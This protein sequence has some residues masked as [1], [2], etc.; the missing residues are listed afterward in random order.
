MERI[1][2]ASVFVRR[3]ILRLLGCKTEHLRELLS[4]RDSA[5]GWDRDVLDDEVEALEASID[6]LK[7]EIGASLTLVDDT[8][9]KGPRSNL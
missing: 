5:S 3:P 9:F 7:V 1:T 2:Q 8:Q 4:L 6:A